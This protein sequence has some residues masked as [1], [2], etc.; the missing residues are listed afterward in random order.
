MHLESTVAGSNPAFGLGVRIKFKRLSKLS[1]KR[2]ER[3]N[4]LYGIL[5]DPK[6]F[7]HLR[8]I[9]MQYELNAIR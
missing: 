8:I 2:L 7:V 3:T 4:D 5:R 1:W 9:R 6:G